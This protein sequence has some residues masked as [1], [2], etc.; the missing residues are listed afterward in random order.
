M[1]Q[2]LEDEERSVC[3]SE[4]TPPQEEEVN[5]SFSADSP[6]N[7]EDLAPAPVQVFKLWQVFVDRVNPLTKLVHVPSFQ[8]LV[9]EASTD[10]TKIPHNAQ[11]LLYAIYMV[12][13]VALTE[14]EAIQMLGMPK[15][16]ALKRFAA[17]LKAALTRANFLEKYD[18]MTLQ[19]MV[20]YLLAIHSRANR[21][22][23]WI[24][25][26][27]LIRMAQKLGLHRDGETLNFTPFEAEMRRRL[28]WQILMSDTKHAIASG[29]HAPMLTW[30]WDTRLPHNVNDADLYP[31]FPGAIQ[32]RDGP[33][34]M[35]F[36]LVLC[37][38]FRFVV[39]NR[40]H[41]LA[42]LS[43]GAQAA[44]KMAKNVNGVSQSNGT[45]MACT[46]PKDMA[47]MLDAKL[48]E[49]ED[50]YVDPSVSPLHKVASRFRNVLTGEL[51]SLL[52]PIHE[53]PEWGTEI[54]NAEDNV[55]R[56]ALIHFERHLDLYE[57]IKDT[58]FVWFFKLHFEPD[59]ILFIASQLQERPLGTLVDRSWTLIDRV[60]T[61]HT[62]LWDMTRKRN[63][64]LGSSILR[65]WRG[66]ERG[67][68]QLG[69]PYDVPSVVSGLKSTVPQNNPSPAPVIE[70]IAKPDPDWLIDQL[71]GYSLDPTGLDGTLDPASFVQA[72]HHF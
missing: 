59:G 52:T 66:R 41:D 6:S 57:E 24:L 55:F 12:S 25:S 37:E 8:P 42:T 11:S 48:L 47:Q 70:A 72:G 30:S 18:M 27:I 35:A 56:I 38:L 61:H 31:N 46:T 60:Y 44:G 69:L 65:A 58:S 32:P 14:V 4:V 64:T 67:L 68:G 7:L 17:G 21:H 51:L 10:H 20:L 1:R 45:P 2:L 3:D 63:V 16:D 62:E 54:F 33:T 50:R 34:E 71:S 23:T 39:E 15:E 5:L 36:F 26:G 22:E 53:L 19:A 9:F 49:I 13:T 29:F 28:W 40:I 43:L